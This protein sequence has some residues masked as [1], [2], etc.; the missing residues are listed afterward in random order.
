MLVD[1]AFEWL[2]CEV[3]SEVASEALDDAIAAYEPIPVG[4]ALTIMEVSKATARDEMEETN[5]TRGV[6]EPRYWGMP[7][8]L[9]ER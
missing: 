4:V 6:A 5:R 8:A 9:W 1:H 3:V 7:D 2:A